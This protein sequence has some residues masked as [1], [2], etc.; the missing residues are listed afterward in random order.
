MRKTRLSSGAY[1]LGNA[2]TDQ[3][4]EI[5][6]ARLPTCRQVLRCVMY[7]IQT[8]A[9]RWEAAK[10]VLAKVAVFCGKAHIPKIRECKSCEGIIKLLDE[11]AKI[12]A[13]PTIRRQTPTSITKVKDMK[14]S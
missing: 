8:G 9:A 11:N 7:H 13:I 2:I 14:L 3:E 12:C 4:S 6:G 10:L 5:T 1:G